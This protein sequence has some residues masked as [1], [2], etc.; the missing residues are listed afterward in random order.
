MVAPEARKNLMRLLIFGQG[1]IWQFQTNSTPTNQW[2]VTEQFD[3]TG[4]ASNASGTQFVGYPDVRIRFKAT[5]NNL[6]PTGFYAGWWIEDIKITAS[7]CELDPP[8]LN[9][10]YTSFPCIQNKPENGLVGNT[11]NNYPVRS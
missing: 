9:F 5:L 6:P 1:N 11:S 4:A 10:N 3:L 8:K 2:W 7:P